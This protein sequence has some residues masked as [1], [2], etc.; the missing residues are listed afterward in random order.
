MVGCRKPLGVK[1]RTLQSA[2]T[3]SNI[4][5]RAPYEI[6][7]SVVAE[8]INDHLR[9]LYSEHPVEIESGGIHQVKPWPGVNAEVGGTLTLVAPVPAWTRTTSTAPSI[10][11]ISW[12]CP[13][14]L[15]S[16]PRG[17]RVG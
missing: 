6:A 10:P 9:V 1:D 7:V 16:P 14:T 8:A 12:A 4:G 17:E 11:A 5:A 3:P 2:V 15:P 13:L